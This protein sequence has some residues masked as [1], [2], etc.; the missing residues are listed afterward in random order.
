MLQ[1]PGP[2]SPVLALVTRGPPGSSVHGPCTVGA[3]AAVNTAWSPQWS[4]TV[5][6]GYKRLTGDAAASPIVRGIGSPNQY[7]FGAS[8]T[9]NF[10]IGN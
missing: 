5:Y 10:N 8:A 9:F 6:A 4:T 7:S 1:W 2:T 3:L